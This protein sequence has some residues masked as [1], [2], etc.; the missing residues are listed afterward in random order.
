[1]NSIHSSN[2][3]FQEKEEKDEKYQ[4]HKTSSNDFNSIQ[5]DDD[6]NYMDKETV[7]VN[8]YN[9]NFNKLLFI[10]FEF[11]IY[12]IISLKK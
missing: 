1:M 8:E 2:S 6:I 3:Y 5:Y 10:I 11:I 7:Y 12:Y 4:H 9:N